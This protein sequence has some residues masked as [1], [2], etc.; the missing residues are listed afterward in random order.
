MGLPVIDRGAGG[1]GIGLPEDEVR[2]PE[3]S[4]ASAACKL[5]SGSAASTT[6]VVGA[7]AVGAWVVGAGLGFEAG[8]CGARAVD[9]CGD[10]AGRAIGGAGR[11]AGGSSRRGGMAAPLERTTGRAGAEAGRGGEGGAGGA[12]AATTA[13]GCTA[14]T[15]SGAVGG[16]AGA[17]TASTT[18]TSGAGASGAVTEA[19]GSVALVLAAAFLAGAFL[20]GTGSSGCSSRTRP[21]RSA[22]RRTRS[23]CAS[24]MLDEC[25]FT[26]MPRSSERSSVSLFVRPSSLASSWT[27]IFA[28]NVGSP[29]LSWF[30]ALRRCAQLRARLSS[31]A[32]SGSRA[33]SRLRDHRGDPTRR[34]AGRQP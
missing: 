18:E 10:E 9:G 27:R 3:L 26:P 23:A 33:R 11:G 12:S 31:L 8:G 24:S 15:A 5:E 14:G 1:G 4:P 20:T 32:Q 7:A 17:G 34:H 28:A 29:A 13:A 22:L 30:G 25:V 16:A 19:T 6:E 21:S 2:P